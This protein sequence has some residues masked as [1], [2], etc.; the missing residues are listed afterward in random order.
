MLSNLRNFSK[1]K[2]ALVLVAIIIIP[3]VF[4]GMGSVFSGGN[5]NN[6]AKINNKNIS[7]K[8]FMNFLNESN[9]DQ[10]YVKN[11]LDEVLQETLG[12]LISRKILLMEINKLSLSLSNQALLSKIK[13]NN[14]FKDENNK[15]SRLK[16]EKFLLENN[17][18]AP[19]FEMKLKSNELQ[20]KLFS[21]INGGLITPYF[22]SN[23]NFI[24]D[25]KSISLDYL[26]L[27]NI[28]KKKFNKTEIDSYINENKENLKRD[29]IDVKYIKIIP[30]NLIDSND[31]NEEFFK[32]IDE[33]ENLIANGFNINE[34]KKRFNFEF[35]EVINYLPKE[36]DNNLILSEIY[37][38]REKNKIELLDK[39]DF[40]FVV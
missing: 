24:K 25:N 4:W 2:L 21:Y 28:Y 11:N 30:N 12:D 34:I 26:N 8:D 33:I 38:Q 37:A 19:A 3:F 23:K 36:D 39:E 40:F 18:S 17:I 6:V 20:K 7:T 1:S 10:D 27:E 14:N 29:F 15:F 35:N 32:K 22:I 5:L 13:S 9:L 31:Y 16:Y